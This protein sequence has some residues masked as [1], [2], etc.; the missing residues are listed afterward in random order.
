MFFFPA[1]ALWGKWAKADVD[2]QTLRT[3]MHDQDNVHTNKLTT[4]TGQL[5]FFNLKLEKVA[6]LVSLKADIISNSKSIQEISGFCQTLGFKERKSLK[7]RWE[8]DTE[9]SED[10]DN[11][12]QGQ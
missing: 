5:E 10:D 9:N 4:L 7:E 6:D 2:V 12:N 8:F 1:V 11:I 3:E